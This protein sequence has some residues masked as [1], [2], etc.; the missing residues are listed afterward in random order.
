MRKTVLLLAS[1]AVAVLLASGVALLVAQKT[2]QAA[3]PG[4]NG[5][6]A[7]DHDGDIFSMNPDGSGVKRLT[8]GRED[9]FDPA[10]SP[11][12]KKIAFVRDPNTYP[13]H[14]PKPVR[15]YVMN[16]DGSGERAITSEDYGSFEYELAWSPSGKKIAYSGYGDGNRHAIFTI[17]VDGSGLRKVSSPRSPCRWHPTPGL[18]REVDYDPAWSP[19]GKKI[20]FGRRCA[21]ADV[22]DVF[23][24][25]AD[26]TH[27]KN[28][29]DDNWGRWGSPD[30]SP[31]GKKVVYSGFYE[32][33]HVM[34]QDGSGK[35]AVPGTRNSSEPV[36]SPEGDRIAFVRRGDIYSIKPDGTGQKQLT[37]DPSYERSPNWQPL[38][39]ESRTG[40]CTITGTSGGDLLIGTP[41]DDVMCGFGGGDVIRGRGGDDTMRGGGGSGTLRGGA[42]DDVL[43]TKDGVRGNDLADGGPGRDVCVANRGVHQAAE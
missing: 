39:T 26:G 25:N 30:W 22:G 1:M 12:G 32:E 18:D 28:L 40:S 17:N 6:I 7:F 3:F 42:G 35:R 23:T 43:N 16:A 5:R 19:D 4:E 24:V 27:E 34:K 41:R 36:W 14:N 15:I 13:T 37:D 20:A 9:D 29:T 2:A 21:A 10:W 11:D 8:E 38:P 31:D 33:I